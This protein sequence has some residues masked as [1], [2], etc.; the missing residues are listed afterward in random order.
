M[1]S[2]I[3]E[4][5]RA[6]LSYVVLALTVVAPA[7]A[8]PARPAD[9]VD[10]FER[11]GW[12]LELGGQ[13]ALETWN[14]NISHEELY[15]WRAGLTYGIREGLTLVA[16]SPV[17]Y[18]AQR[19]T[20]AFL[21]GAT[22]G[23]RGRIYRRGKVS[24]FLEVDLGVSESDTPVPPRGTRFNYLALGGG[25]ATIRVRRGMYLL[26]GLKWIHI[27][28]N[29]LAGRNRNPDI[30]AVGPQAALLLRF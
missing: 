27:S 29:G 21:I 23:I 14:Y 19:R 16:G 1:R 5:L 3:I 26:T 22:I 7:Q 20:D 12:H 28:N 13:G 2:T 25:G 30:E 17:W 11:R 15:G 8:Q 18:V 9:A 10:P 24:A 4:A 6:A